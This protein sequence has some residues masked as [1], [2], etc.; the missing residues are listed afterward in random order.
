MRS[1]AGD[2]GLPGLELDSAGTAAYHVGEAPD[3]RS[4]A[5]ASRRGISLQGS[6]RQ[7]RADDFERFDLLVAMDRSNRDELLALAPD[8]RAAAKVRLLREYDPDAVAAGTLDVPDP[9]YG[10]PNGFDDVLDGVTVA[11]RGLL[12]KLEASARS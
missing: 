9:Y 4:A 2:S 10:G 6:A 12:D 1:L 7:V 11:C 8:E 5:A 3:R